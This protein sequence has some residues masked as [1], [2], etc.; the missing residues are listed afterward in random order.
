MRLLPGASASRL[1]SP[2]LSLPRARPRCVPASSSAC[3]AASS[4][5][6]GAGDGGARKPW[7]FVGLGNPGKVY[8]GTRHN[9]GFE[10]IDV[11]SE[12]EGIPLSSMQFKAMVGKGRIG[13][14]PVML[15]KPQTFMNASGESVGQ[16]VSYFKIPLNQVVVMYDDLDLPFAKLRL[17]P[18]G[19]HGGHN[20][21]RSIINHLKQSRDFPR[22]RIGIGRPPGKMDPANFVL[23]PFTKREQEELDFAFHRGLEAVRIM[24]LEGFNKSA[25]Y[26]NTTQSSEM[27]N[28]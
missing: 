15:A 12:A 22:L 5:A 3:R 19:G 24:V 17:L 20:G 10:M 8:Q 4:S 14:A 6:A 25:T 16:L 23:R 9:V 7:L 11:I 2:L 18:K 28:R 13:D 1:P 21:M 27:L 26:V